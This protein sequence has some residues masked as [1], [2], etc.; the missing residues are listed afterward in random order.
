MRELHDESRTTGLG[1]THL[2]E[3]FGKAA[4]EVIAAF[5]LRLAGE[6]GQQFMHTPVPRFQQRLLKPIHAYPS[7]FY[8]MVANVHTSNA[9]HRTLVAQ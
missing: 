2:V 9:D 7:Q 4:Q 8:V 3:S 6:H 5:M 1:N